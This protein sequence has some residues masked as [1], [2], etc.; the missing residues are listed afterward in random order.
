MNPRHAKDVRM[1]A[2]HIGLRLRRR[3]DRY[4]IYDNGCRV[5]HRRAGQRVD[6]DRLSQVV[7]WLT[8]YMDRE[9]ARLS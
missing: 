9:I 6:F 1:W 3:G 7:N 4:S 2:Q 8:K 5:D